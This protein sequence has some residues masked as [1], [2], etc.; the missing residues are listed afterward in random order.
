MNTNGIIAVQSSHS[1]EDTV[2]SL[3]RI[4]DAKGLTLFALVDHSGE[5]AKVSM[6]M[7]SMKLLIFGNPQAGT[8]V[9]VAAPSSALDLPLKILVYE[10]HEGR[11]LVAYNDPAY[12]QQRHGIPDTLLA[13]IAGVAALVA[14]VSE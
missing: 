4:F 6:T 9:M 13:K 3:Q 11:V 12:L 14:K 5:A 8:P 1:V 2:A 10:D 7:R